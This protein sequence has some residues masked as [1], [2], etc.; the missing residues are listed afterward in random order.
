MG[1][2]Q[3]QERNRKVARG[4]PRPVREPAAQAQEQGQQAEG[5][6]ERDDPQQTG[7]PLSWPARA[8]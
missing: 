7:L 4:G 5:D 3:E 2:E 1:D 8:R 6:A